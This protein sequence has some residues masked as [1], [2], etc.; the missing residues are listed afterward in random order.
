[1]AGL[2]N[3]LRVIESAQLFTG[4][5]AGQLLADEGADVVKFESPF[6]GDYLRDFLGQI[7]PHTRGHSPLHMI[8][9]RNK[10]S[11]AVDLR[12]PEGKDIFWM[13]LRNADVFLDGNTT[14][15]T[16]KLG[17]GYETQCKVK[18][19]IIYAHVTGL[20][21]SGPY[22]MVPTHGQSMSSVAGA[23]SYERG[24]DGFPKP[25]RDASN[26]IGGRSPVVDGPLYLAYA[27]AAALFRRERTGIGAYIDVAASDASISAAWME[28]VQ[29]MNREKIGADET[30]RG[31]S[32]TGGANSKYNV[33]ETKDGR[34]MLIAL[35]EHHFW[36]QFCRGIGREDLLDE[37]VGYVSKNV[38]IDWGP[39]ELR[40]ELRTIMASKTAEEWMAFAAEHDV[41]MAPVNSTS[42]LRS[43]PHLVSREAIIDYVHPTAGTITVTGNPIKVRGESYY[44][45]Q[46]APALG[47]HTTEYLTELGIEPE[48]REQLNKNGIT[49]SP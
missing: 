32:S 6:R 12:T 37:E 23:S 47:E 48:H 11:V 10:R 26:T 42:D 33:Y 45:R 9:N 27:I 30:G 18:P 25:T 17:I 16:E 8:L 5:F 7:K 14:G 3:G 46:P 43:D 22:A 40:S 15:A 29:I 38:A 1:L 20:G 4:D 49:A 28:V 41:V 44:V 34:F 31:G 19:D 39:P 24:E 13:A 2:L 35:I 21:A 36:E